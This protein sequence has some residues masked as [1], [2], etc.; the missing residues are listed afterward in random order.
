MRQ[1]A[2]LFKD[3]LSHVGDIF[4][5]GIKA[6]FGQRLTCCAVTKFGFFTQREQGFPAAHFSAFARHVQHFL[7]AH[8]RLAR[9]PRN[10]GKGAI[11]ANVATQVS[12]GDKDLAR[13]RD[14]AAVFAIPQRG[15][16]RHQGLVVIDQ[17]QRAGLN[18]ARQSPIHCL[19]ENPVTVMRE[20]KTGYKFS[21]MAEPLIRIFPE[22]SAQSRKIFNSIDIERHLRQ[23]QA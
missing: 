3:G 23:I 21:G 13:I 7:N 17:H 19:I 11:V 10:L 20:T 6:E 15:C 8:E 12:Q 16:G 5:R 4:Q 2:G 22:V 9:V 18:G 14:Q 1:Q